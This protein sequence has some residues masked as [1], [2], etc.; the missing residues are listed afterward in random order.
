MLFYFI[1]I[2]KRADNIMI[3]TVVIIITKP[4]PAS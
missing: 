2:P 3:I 4:M 1:V